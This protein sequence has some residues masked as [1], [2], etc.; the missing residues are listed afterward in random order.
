MMLLRAAAYSPLLTG[1][2]QLRYASLSTLS[3]EGCVGTNDPVVTQ[4]A[5]DINDRLA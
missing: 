5:N 3:F 1:M 4:L 2:L